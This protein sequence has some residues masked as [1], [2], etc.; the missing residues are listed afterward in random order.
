MN[1]LTKRI[2]LIAVLLLVVFL[3]AWPKLRGL[4]DKEKAQNQKTAQNANRPIPVEVVVIKPQAYSNNLSVT[5]SV[6]ANEMLELKSEV[7]GILEN[8]NF[9]EGQ[10]VKKG[11]LLFTIRNTDLQA[12]LQKAKARQQLVAGSENRYR[13]LLEREAVSQEEYDIATNDLRSAEADIQLLEAQIAKTRV[14]APFD[15]NVGLRLASQG[16]YIAAGTAI[17]SLYDLQPAKI[18]FSVPGKYQSVIKPGD[19][20]SFTTDGSRK[21]FRGEIYALEPQ[22]DP[23]TRSLKIRALSPNED[24]SLLPGQF[25]RISLSLEATDNALM[26][27]TQAVVPEL[28]GHKVYLLKQGKVAEQVVEI[29]SRSATQVQILSGINAGDSV[30]TTG[31]LQVRPGSEVEVKAVASLGEGAVQNQQ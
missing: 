5:G 27:P 19:P 30:L 9:K 16:S 8:I 4:T 11:Q 28:N 7:P 10:P 14:Y 29:G 18:D 25:A 2:I 24:K 12:Q 31:I 20:I 6:L 1:K 17:A 3:I 26:V 13:Q 21:E 23:A 22:I 15:G